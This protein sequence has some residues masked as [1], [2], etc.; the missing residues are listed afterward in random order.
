MLWL[1]L[2]IVV[3]IILFVVLSY[4]MKSDSFDWKLKTRHL[5]TLLA[6][7]ILIPGCVTKV[8]VNSVGIKYSPFNGTSEITLSEGFHFKSPLDTVYKISTEI[9]TK[10]VENLTTQ[11]RD[12]QYI[13][14]VLDVKYK[15]N[16]SN[17]FM[18]FKQYRTLDRMSNNF[19]V[20]TVQRVLEQVTTTYNVIDILGEKRTEIYNVLEKNLVDE[21]A[22]YGIEFVSITINDMDA[23]EAIEQAITAEAV[24]K[25]A[26]ETAEQ[27]LAKAEIEASQKSVLA[28]AEKEAATIEAETKLIQARAE[29][30]ANELLQQSLTE[31]I[32]KQLWIEKWNGKVPTYYG[33]NGTDLIFNT[34]EL[35]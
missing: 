23:G 24:A 18:V 30:E 6:L 21:F 12:A 16:A 3:G 28:L 29:K 25:K 20:P 15:V 33:G 32:L 31:A 1:I 26:V 11:T 14:S 5:F 9:Q 8:P 19:I 27:E 22:L 17:A 10:N 2:S 35:E 13:N 34:G 4:D 7:L